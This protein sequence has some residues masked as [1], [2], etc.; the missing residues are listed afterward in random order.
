MKQAANPSRSIRGVASVELAVL[1]IPLVIMAFGMVELG[2]AFY[3]YNALVKSVRNASRYL[4]MHQR[5]EVNAQA[6]C[7]AVHGNTSCGGDPLL[8]GLET[9]M[10]AIAYESAVPTG[11]GSIDLVT[12]TI[13]GYPFSTLTSMPVDAMRFGDISSTMRQGAS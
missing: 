13:S 5:N 10:V 6:R 11:H 7:L 4:S 9:G 2:R 1:L 12:V 8:A 3:H